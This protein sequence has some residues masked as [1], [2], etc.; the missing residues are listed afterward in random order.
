VAYVCVPGLELCSELVEIG[1][2]VRNQCNIIS[3]L[4]KE[5]SDGGQCKVNSHASRLAEGELRTTYAEA[6]PVPEEFPTPATTKMGRV[7]ITVQR[8]TFNRRPSTT[9]F[10]DV[11]SA[12]TVSTLLLTPR[13]LG[14]NQS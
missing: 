12:T 10:S 7:D 11:T 1:T 3:S 14:H 2:L 8:S 6:P 13:L 5:A 4:G 9:A